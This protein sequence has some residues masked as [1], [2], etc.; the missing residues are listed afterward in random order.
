L[1]SSYGGGG[2]ITV[3]ISRRSKMTRLGPLARLFNDRGLS[4][5]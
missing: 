2:P 4:G 3:A 1:F 5:N